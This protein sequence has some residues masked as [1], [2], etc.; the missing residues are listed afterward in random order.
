LQDELEQQLGNLDRDGRGAAMRT[1]DDVPLRIAHAASRLRRLLG[2][3]GPEL[4]LEPVHELR[5]A[6]KR[7]R[8]V[9]EE[10]APLPGFDFEKSLARLTS[11]QQ[12]LGAVCD[13]EFAAARLLTW[14]PPAAAAGT[15]HLLAAAAIGGMVAQLTLAAG[16]A[17]K[18]ARREL[19]RTD[20][21]R[22]WR[23][24]ATEAS[25]PDA[26]VAT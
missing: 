15:D 17:R 21:K 23:R 16:K 4:P 20:R 18:V 22:V 10:F 24:F 1:A 26:N 3:I 11:L 14:L 9:A 8:Y 13:H 25:P 19:S 7:L 5:I 12:A 6:A 2:A